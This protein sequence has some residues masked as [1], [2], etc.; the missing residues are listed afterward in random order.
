MLPN[1]AQQLS[2]LLPSLYGHWK[3]GL[4]CWLSNAVVTLISHDMAKRVSIDW[5]WF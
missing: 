3:E 2:C 5:D 4:V 1:V